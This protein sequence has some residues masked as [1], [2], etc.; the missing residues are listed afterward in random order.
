MIEIDIP[1]LRKSIGGVESYSRI[2]DC[3]RHILKK[4]NDDK[5]SDG[6]CLLSPYEAHRFSKDYCLIIG[7]SYPYI[8]K[9]LLELSYLQ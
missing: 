9:V 5:Y 6:W 1:V 3:V 2:M 8:R 4:Y 7:G